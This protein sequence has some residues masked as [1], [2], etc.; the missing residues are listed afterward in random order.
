MQHIFIL[1][2]DEQIKVEKICKG[3]AVYLLSGAAAFSLEV[4]VYIDKGWNQGPSWWLTLFLGTSTW[5]LAPYV[6]MSWLI[7][8][9][10]HSLRQ[11]ILMLFGSLGVTLFGI[12]MLLDGFFIHHDERSWIIYVLVPIYQWIAFG[13]TASI[14]YAIGS[15]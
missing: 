14:R 8:Q 12:V 13:A 9:K 2:H 11:Y 5:L 1:E 6:G 3:L 15:K 10:K 7:L 4:I